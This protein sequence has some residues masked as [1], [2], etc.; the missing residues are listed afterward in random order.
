MTNWFDWMWWQ[1][2]S[3]V[4]LPLTWFTV[5]NWCVRLILPMPMAYGKCLMK[6]K[7]CIVICDI[8]LLLFLS[9][10]L[11]VVMQCALRV[12]CIQFWLLLLKLK[13]I[14]N[15]LRAEWV[16]SWLHLYSASLLQLFELLDVVVLRILGGLFWPHYRWHLRYVLNITLRHAMFSP[17]NAFFSTLIHRT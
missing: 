9:C 1:V 2:S 11:Y 14:V 7:W 16:R 12:N 10:M 6:P 5:G 17:F 13:T 8:L 4:H 3:E 15:R